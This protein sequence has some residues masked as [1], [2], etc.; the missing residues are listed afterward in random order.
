MRQ[1]FAWPAGLMFDTCA[2]EHLAISF[3]SLWPY[4][5]QNLLYCQIFYNVT[6]K[7]HGHQVAQSLLSIAEQ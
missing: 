7:G 2:L 1:W 6:F 3:S 5:R 4:S